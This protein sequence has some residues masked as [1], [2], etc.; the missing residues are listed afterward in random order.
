M[1]EAG[2]VSEFSALK[3]NILTLQHPLYFFSI[4]LYLINPNSA[5]GLVWLL[6]SHHHHSSRIRSKTRPR[7]TVELV[8]LNIE[9]PD[10]VSTNNDVVF[11][12]ENDPFFQA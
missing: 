3:S 10:V 7:A 8:S 12:L 6:F 5:F 1:K 11:F 4:F 9:V 2:F